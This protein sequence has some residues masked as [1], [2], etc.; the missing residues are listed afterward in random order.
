MADLERSAAISPTVAIY[1][2]SLG[3]YYAAQG[4]DEKVKPLVEQLQAAP[5]SDYV[6]HWLAGSLLTLHDRA[7]AIAELQA[8]LEAPGVPPLIAAAIH[9]A[10]GHQEV[11]SGTVTAAACRVRGG[12]APGARTTSTP[13]SGWAILPGWKAMP[14][15]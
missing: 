3:G 13:R 1:T 5:Q 7:A 4:Q 9:I 2:G 12:A 14:R 8:A 15:V 6:A 11:L 10:V